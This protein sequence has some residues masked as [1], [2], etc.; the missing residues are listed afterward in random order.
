M[1]TAASFQLTRGQAA[2][3]CT[4]ANY[5]IGTLEAA[6]IDQKYDSAPL[7]RGMLSCGQAM[8]L[9]PVVLILLLEK[10][11]DLREEDILNIAVHEAALDCAGEQEN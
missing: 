7:P 8:R 1:D 6:C 4:E 2:I 10:F 9:I 11:P 3:L 5:V